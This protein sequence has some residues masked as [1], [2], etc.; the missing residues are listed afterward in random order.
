MKTDQ[1][2][3]AVSIVIGQIDYAFAKDSVFKIEVGDTPFFCCMSDCSKSALAMTLRMATRGEI[4]LG[5]GTP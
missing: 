5:I 2:R 4:G 3:G 1:I